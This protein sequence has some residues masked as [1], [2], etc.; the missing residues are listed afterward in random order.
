MKALITILLLTFSLT[1]LAAT[2]SS[3]T[4]HWRAHSKN[5]TA[6]IDHSAFAAFLQQYVVK[7]EDAPNLV[8]YSKVTPAD[9]KR[10]EAYIQKLEHVQLRQYNRYVQLAYWL[11]LY[12]A[13]LIDLVLD[14]YPLKHVYTI[15]GASA[16]PWAIPVVTIDGYKLSL[17]DIRHYILDPIWQERVIDYGLSWAAMGGPELRA[18][19]YHGKDIFIQ[20]RHAAKNFV[21]SPQALTIKNSHLILSR[22]FDWFRFEFG[23][24]TTAVISQVREHSYPDRSLRLDIFDAIYGF[25][26]DWRL[27][28]A[29]L[30]N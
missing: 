1:T 5:S 29:K 25:T 22:F 15:G 30:V 20:L 10:L 16:S 24:S 26:F 27:N 7:R 17:N 4:E 11:N 2:Q 6:T 21:N 9:H 23:G 28:D 8:R 18:K 19:P 14:H 12:N 13:A 3:L